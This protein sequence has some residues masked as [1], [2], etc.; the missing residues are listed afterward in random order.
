MSSAIRDKDQALVLFS[1]DYFVNC[2]KAL[3]HNAESTWGNGSTLC[4]GVL[5][6]RG[7]RNVRIRQGRHIWDICVTGLD[8]N[9]LVIGTVSFFSKP[10][11]YITS[12]IPGVPLVQLL[13]DF[14]SNMH[15]G[16][17]GLLTLI[18]HIGYTARVSSMRGA[19]AQWKS[20]RD[21][22]LSGPML[23]DDP[24]VINSWSRVGVCICYVVADNMIFNIFESCESGD[25][26]LFPSDWQALQEILEGLVDSNWV[27]MPIDLW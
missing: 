3:V 5:F 23:W 25:P 22:I 15:T 20:L 27:T 10:N 26:G 14:D 13:E 17:H 9:G 24:K 4:D 11:S 7:T 2:L 18:G 6:Y 19:L 8:D 16:A 21:T 1:Y 12:I